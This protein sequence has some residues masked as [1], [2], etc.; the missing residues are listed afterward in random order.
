MKE[1]GSRRSLLLFIALL[2]I[3]EMV[4]YRDF[5]FMTKESY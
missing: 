4:V 1:M 3:L 2:I 5:L